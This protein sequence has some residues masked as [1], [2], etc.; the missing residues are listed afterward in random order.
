VRH[1]QLALVFEHLTR[2]VQRGAHARAAVAEFAWVL[3]DQLRELGRILDARGGRGHQ[4]QR[5]RRHQPDGGEVLDVVL[6]L[7]GDQLVDGQLVAGAHQ[8][9]VAIGLGIGHLLRANGAARTAEVLDHHRL[10]Q[11]GGQL[12]AHHAAHQ[13]GAA[14]GRVGHDDGDGLGGVRWGLGPGRGYGGGTRQCTGNTSDKP[15][16]AGNRERTH[17]VSLCGVW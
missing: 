7:F 17:R 2:Q 16:A 13:V 11:A 8:Q 1:E 4:H 5:L 3:G 10:A 6:D 14:A 9:R 12:S 15:L